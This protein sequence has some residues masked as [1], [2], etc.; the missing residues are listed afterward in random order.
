MGPMDVFE[1]GRMALVQDPQGAVFA[2]WQPRQHIGAR[3]K[4]DPG[5]MTWNELLTTDPDAATEFYGALFGMERVDTTDMGGYILLRVQG[6]EVAGLMK[7]TEDMG[8]VP[9]C[10]TVYFAVDDVSGAVADAQEMGSG[11]G[12]ARHGRS[13]GWSL[14]CLDGPDGGALQRF[15]GGLRG[16]RGQKDASVHKTEAS[17]LLGV[18]PGFQFLTRPGSFPPCLEMN[19]V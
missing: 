9:P 3:V 12:G 13:R 5:A 6:T 1:A 17:L 18:G 19:P 11:G 10:W 8:P 14:R 7:I 2:V 4:D 15:Q 16:G